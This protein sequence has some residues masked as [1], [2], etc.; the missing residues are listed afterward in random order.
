[1]EDYK[2]PQENDRDIEF[3]KTVKAGKRIY[4][5]DVKRNRKGD[6]YIALTESKKILAANPNSPTVTFEKHKIFLY[7]EDFDKFTDGLND[8]IRFIRNQNPN[9][10]SHFS[11][12]DNPSTNDDTPDY[13]F[14]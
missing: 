2:T 12:Q 3:T 13:N 10:Q 6:Y 7:Q 5:V 9:A 8:A 14:F 11:S 1:M 4:Y